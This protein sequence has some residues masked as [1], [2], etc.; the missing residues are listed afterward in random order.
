MSM[1]ETLLAL[2]FALLSVLSCTGMLFTRDTVVAAVYLIVAACAVVGLAFVVSYP[3]FA[4]VILLI[5]IGVVVTFIIVAASAL[6]RYRPFVDKYRKAAFAIVLATILVSILVGARRLTT[7]TMSS[8]SL[9]ELCLCTLSKWWN[10]VAILLIFL[11][12]IV[13]AIVQLCRRGLTP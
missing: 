10:V 6:E 5:Y 12:T 8:I 1:T 9:R 2:I 13:L 4:I 3:A 7:P 11:V